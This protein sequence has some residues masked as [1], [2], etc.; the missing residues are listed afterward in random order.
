MATATGNSVIGVQNLLN[1]VVVVSKL[2]SMS[3][4]GRT[5][6]PIRRF[7]YF[8]LYTFETSALVPHYLVE[9]GVVRSPGL[10]LPIRLAPLGANY[11]YR[12]DVL[13]NVP[14]IAWSATVV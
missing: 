3:F 5:Q 12:L 1:N 10:L 14:A 9:E 7:G 8:Y 13:W 6:P 4:P 11:L 2:M